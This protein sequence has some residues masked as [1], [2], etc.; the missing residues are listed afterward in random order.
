MLLI[1]DEFES[2]ATIFF[3][4][5]AAVNNIILFRLSTHSTHFIQ[6]LDVRVFQSYKY[7]HAETIDAAIRLKNR[8]FEKLKFF[9]VFQIFRNQ[10]FKSS[11]IRHAFRITRIMFFNFNM[12]FDII[13]QKINNSTHQF[14]TL[15]LQFQL[16]KKIFKKSKFIKKF[17]QKIERALKNI[18]SNKNIMIKK[19]VDRVQ[20]FVRSTMTVVNT[21]NFIIRDLNMFQRV[22]FARRIRAELINTIAAKKKIMKINQCRKLCS[23][24]QKKKKK[25]KT[26]TK[27][28]KKKTSQITQSLINEFATIA[29][30]IER[31][32]SSDQL[33]F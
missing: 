5:L 10:I 33:I 26:K 18:G 8:E 23:I 17:E 13:R 20:R 16:V 24:R 3:F 4:E 31:N 7:Y 11:T 14:R 12:I 9:A 22:S 6:S 19:N 1:V 32:D 29:Y 27:T 15:S 30:L 21:L 25:I 28:K 2:H